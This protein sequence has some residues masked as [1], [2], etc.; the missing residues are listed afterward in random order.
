M[1]DAYAQVS[2]AQN[3]ARN[4]NGSYFQNVVKG[5]VM[6]KFMGKGSILIYH[7]RYVSASRYFSDFAPV[8]ASFGGSSLNICHGKRARRADHFLTGHI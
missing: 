1:L 6:R 7:L 3:E 2:I 8:D 5:V 4:K